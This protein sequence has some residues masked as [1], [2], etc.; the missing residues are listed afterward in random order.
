MN[1]ALIGSGGR[2]H[3]LCQKI[4][5]SKLSKNIICIPGNAGTS[6]IAKNIELNF[7]NF[8][9]LLKTLKLHKINLVIVGPEEPLVRGIV[10]FLNKHKIKVFGV[11]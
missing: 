3:A 2:E 8:K 11:L 9:E 10:D 4:H 1:I 7:L 5:D 6:R